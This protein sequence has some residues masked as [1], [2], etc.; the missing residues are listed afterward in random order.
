MPGDNRPSA[1]SVDDSNKAGNTI[2]NIRIHGIEQVCMKLEKSLVV[3]EEWC[4]K[5]MRAEA[6]KGSDPMAGIVFW[7]IMDID[8]ALEGSGLHG[9]FGGKTALAIRGLTITGVPGA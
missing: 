6:F 2:L 5:A 9:T 1:M 8:A 4:G 3:L 7:A